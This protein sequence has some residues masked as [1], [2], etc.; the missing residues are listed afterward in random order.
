MFG[1]GRWFRGSGLLLRGSRGWSRLHIVG[2]PTKVCKP[3][4]AACAQMGVGG[5][6]N[7]VAVEILGDGVTGTPAS[8]M[9]RMLPV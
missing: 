4:R 9:A 2:I 8:C 1:W 6:V 7:G 5:G 3:G